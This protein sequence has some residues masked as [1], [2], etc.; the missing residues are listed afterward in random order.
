VRRDAQSRLPA[1]RSLF[2][3]VT[4]AAGTFAAVGHAQTVRP[5]IVEYKESAKGKFELINNGLQPATVVVEPRGFTV[6]EDGEGIY[7]PLA[8]NI[9]LKLSSM[10]L[11]IPPKQSRY[12]FYEAKADALPA[13]FVIYSVFAGPAQQSGLNI[14]LDLPHTVY[15]FQKEPLERSDVT[16]E[17][18]SY[19]PDQHRVVIV[20]A[21]QS[22]KLGRALEWQIASRGT[23]TGGSGFPLLP[24][25]RRQLEVAWNAADPPATFSIRFE[26]FSFKE[27][28]SASQK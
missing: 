15:L 25:N 8:K 6:K 10:S 18:L 16:V 20:I 11:R 28:F 27:E 23:K 3:L 22:G 12:I 26:H 13:W 14:Q 21:N 1:Q 7:G 9:H 17:S 19:H 24:Q 4:L 5:V 2:A